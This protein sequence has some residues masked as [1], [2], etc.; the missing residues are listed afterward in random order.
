VTEYEQLAERAWGDILVCGDVTPALALADYL[1][2]RGDRRG[3]QIRHLL[4]GFPERVAQLQAALDAADHGRSLAQAFQAALL[5][6]ALLAHTAKFLCILLCNP[7]SPPPITHE[8][9]RLCPRPHSISIP[10]DLVP[11]PN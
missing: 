6:R 10:K 4:T 1:E 7:D 9:V 2:E 11:P 8:F 5:R 3:R